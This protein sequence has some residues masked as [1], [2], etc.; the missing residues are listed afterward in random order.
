MGSFHGRT[1]SGVIQTDGFEFEDVP[2]QVAGVGDLGTFLL[3][4]CMINTLIGIFAQ[5]D[6]SNFM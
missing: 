3:M 2:Y 1:G 5:V 4:I 6:L